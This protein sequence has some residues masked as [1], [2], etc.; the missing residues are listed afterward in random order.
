MSANVWTPDGSGINIA[1]VLEA[2]KSLSTTSTPVV[3]GNI[4]FQA[5]P[6]KFFNVGS[7]LLVVYRPDT[8]N[9]MTGQVVSYDVSTGVL[10][11]NSQYGQYTTPNPLADWQ[12]TV[13]GSQAPATW[14]GGTVI[15]PATFQSTAT[16]N[17]AVTFGAGAQLA[18]GTRIR[19]DPAGSN[20]AP[21]G[22][23]EL[24]DAW[25]VAVH[26]TPIGMIADFA[27]GVATPLGWLECNGGAI[28]RTDFPELFAYLGTTYGSG[29]GVTTFNVPNLSRRV[30]VGRGGT[31]TG[32]LGNT[33]SAVGG[34][35]TH[36]LNN[37]ELPYHEHLQL[38]NGSASVSAGGNPIVISSNTNSTPTTGVGANV[39]HNNMQPS[40]VVLTCIKAFRIVGMNTN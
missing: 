7:W 31:G 3:G 23:D 13:S 12:I 2:M 20:L 30:R 37:N 38:T 29:D 39:A 25:Q 33:V 1:E 15:N 14:S 40:M 17:G 32:I 9:W 16:F 18:A 21:V 27:R 5:E 36:Q 24:V 4:T 19:R 11:F 34:F 22:T 35:E 6:N 10:V 28:S 8:R 26:G